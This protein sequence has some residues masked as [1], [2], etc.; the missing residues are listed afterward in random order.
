MYYVFWIKDIL[1]VTVSN[2]VV[3]LL[4]IFIFL[5]PK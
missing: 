2:V 3:D 4:A 5:L 1:G